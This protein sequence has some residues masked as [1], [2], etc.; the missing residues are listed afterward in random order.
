MIYLNIILYL[1]T[2]IQ[3][4]EVSLQVVKLTLKFI[5]K[6]AGDLGMLGPLTRIHH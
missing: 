3:I 2:C 1:L 4:L 5:L 6:I